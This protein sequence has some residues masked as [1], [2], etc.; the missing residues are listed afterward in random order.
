MTVANSES[1]D[2]WVFEHAQILGHICTAIKGFV[3][4]EYVNIAWR[5]ETTG[6]TVDVVYG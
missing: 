2:A 1:V 4:G 5:D 3:Q 6:E